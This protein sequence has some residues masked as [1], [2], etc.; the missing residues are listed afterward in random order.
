MRLT[1]VAWTRDRQ[2]R[3]VLELKIDGHSAYIRGS[4][5]T[6]LTRRDIVDEVVF[7]NSERGNQLPNVYIHRDHASA[8]QGVDRAYAQVSE[9]RGASWRRHTGATN[10]PTSLFRSGAASGWRHRT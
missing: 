4:Q 7:L 8:Y 2:G 9:G 5:Q 10:M 3:P 6:E 1:D